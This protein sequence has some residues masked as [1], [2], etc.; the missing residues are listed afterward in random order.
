M[1][2]GQ[3]RKFSWERPPF[4]RPLQ[5]WVGFEHSERVGKEHF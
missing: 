1:A 5:N 2:G 3:E 4:N